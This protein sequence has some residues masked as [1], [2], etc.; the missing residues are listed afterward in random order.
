ME[1]PDRMLQFLQD[2][3]RWHLYIY[4][5]VGTVSITITTRVVLIIGID[6]GTRVV[7]QATKIDAFPQDKY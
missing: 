3:F 2:K 7:H 5:G 1:F 4:R 6:V